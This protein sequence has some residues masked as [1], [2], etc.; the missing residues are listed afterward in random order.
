MNAIVS[1]PQLASQHPLQLA[2]A[3]PKLRLRVAVS[4]FVLAT[5][6]P[7]IYVPRKQSRVSRSLDKV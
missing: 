2:G 7:D 6:N 3:S 5:F 4:T 1:W